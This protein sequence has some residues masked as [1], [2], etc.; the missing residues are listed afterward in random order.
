MNNKWYINKS[1]EVVEFGT[2]LYKISVGYNKGGMN[3]WNY[4]TERRGYYVHFQPNV[5]RST[6]DIISE[7]FT[8]LDGSAF[9]VLLRE[10]K[11]ASAKTEAEVCKKVESLIA[12][13]ARIVSSSRDENAKGDEV[14]NIFLA[15]A[16]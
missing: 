10:V 8:M 9:K 6:G 3:Y 7:S 5:T 4:K 12:D 15:L 14:G 2:E 13:I 16:A 1:G 11:R